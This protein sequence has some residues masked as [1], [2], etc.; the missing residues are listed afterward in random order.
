MKLTLPQTLISWTNHNWPE[1]AQIG[2]LESIELEVRDKLPFGSSA[3]AMTW[4]GRVLIRRSWIEPALHDLL[5]G[6]VL[7]PRHLWAISVLAFHEPHHVIEQRGK[8][9][10]GYLARYVWQWI[11]GGFSY[12]KID[13]EEH[14]YE[15]QADLEQRYW[16]EVGRLTDNWQRMRPG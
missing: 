10:W 16:A 13:E 8:S 4:R 5:P 9:W 3:A 15:H 7:N 11:R 6:N 1:L 14:A 2:G 12:R